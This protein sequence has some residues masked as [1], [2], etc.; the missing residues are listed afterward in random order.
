MNILVKENKEKFN[1]F[2]YEKI[3]LRQ[4][5]YKYLRSYLQN[6][7][8]KLY[9]SSLININ[10]DSWILILDGDYLLVYGENWSREQF[11]EIKELIDWK[12]SNNF[13]V[14]GN[15][16]LI[17][18]LI[19]F[20]GISNYKIEKERIFYKSNNINKYSSK[21]IHKAK[22]AEQD[23]LAN[24]LK[25]YYHEEY[26]GKYDKPINECRKDIFKWIKDGKIYALKNSTGKILSFCTVLNPDIGILFTK[27]KYRNQ[28]NGKI[29]LSYCANILLRKN[30]EIYIMT[31]KNEKASN[32]V[33]EKIGFNPFYNYSQLGINYT[34]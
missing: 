20:W 27:Q 5:Q 30:N 13:Q 15:S 29:L 14:A 23:E 24:M 8:N 21:N 26:K 12:S 11:L 32:I 3:D 31:D 25:L 33:C 28:G 19:D 2:L 7:N 17:F 22:F 10:E 18:D 9:D 1:D 4:F 16:E 34:E 6:K